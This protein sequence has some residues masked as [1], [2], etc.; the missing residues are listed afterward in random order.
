[1]YGYQQ[2]PGQYMQQ[3]FGQQNMWQ[4]QR[5]GG[6]TISSPDEIT[7]QDVPSDGSLALFPMADGSCV[8]GK[9]WEPN[10]SISTYRYLP[11]RTEAQKEPDRID[12]LNEKVDKIIAYLSARHRKESNEPA[13]S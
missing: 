1:M 12:Q 8:Y 2:Y 4:V 6:R 11:E 9:R 3:P 7:V 5:P 13:A 10:G